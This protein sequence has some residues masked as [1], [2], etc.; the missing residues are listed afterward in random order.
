MRRLEKLPK[1]MLSVCK[2]V[3]RKK[4]V[5]EKSDNNGN[6]EF[7]KDTFLSPFTHRR[8]LICIGSRANKWYSTKDSRYTNTYICTL[9][10]DIDVKNLKKTLTQLEKNDWGSIP[11]E[12]PPSI[13]KCFVLRNKQLGE[14]SLADIRLLIGQGIGLDYLMP[15]AVDQLRNNPLAHCDHYPGDLLANVLRAGHDFYQKNPDVFKDVESIFNDS[16]PS[17]MKGL[18]KDDAECALE[19]LNEA[20]Q[21]F[22]MN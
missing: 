1:T 20:I 17:A 11:D 16:V 8:I 14:L 15:I 6:S 21:L 2:I 19:S 22:R 3:L 13:K 5:N 10:D 4:I 18:D 7:A 12:A 9:V